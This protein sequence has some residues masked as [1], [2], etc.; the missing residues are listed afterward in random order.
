[1]LTSNNSNTST[2]NSH[3]NI[4]GNDINMV[5]LSTTGVDCWPTIESALNQ[6]FSLPTEVSNSITLTSEDYLK[7]YTLVCEYCVG[8]RGKNNVK[9]NNGAGLICGKDMY[10]AVFHYISHKISKWA[11]IIKV[12]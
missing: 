12:A 2:T 4:N 1:M 8:A 5:S 3:D 7:L 9:E 10:E 6:L 11:E